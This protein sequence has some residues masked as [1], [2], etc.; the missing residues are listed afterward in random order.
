[1][2][3]GWGTP[4]VY[5][6]GLDLGGVTASSSGT[7]V[8]TGA[9]NTKGNWVQLIASTPNDIS[10]IVL[11]VSTYGVTSNAI[12]VDLACAT[13]G[14]ESS[15]V[16]LSNLVCQTSLPVTHLEIPV[17]VKAGSRIAARAASG[18]ATDTCNIQVIGLNSGYTENVVGSVI[19][20]YGYSGTGAI[21]GVSVDPGGTVNTLGAYAVLTASTTKD[22]MGFWLGFDYLNNVPTA[23]SDGHML[24]NLA[25]GPSTE[26]VVIPN[27]AVCKNMFTGGI[28]MGPSFS[29]FYY[30]PI[31]AGTRVVVNARSA[32]NAAT[33]RLL[34]VSLYGLRA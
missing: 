14:N 15:G 24:L 9:I 27:I 30:I 6:P 28:Q 18:N 31:K 22:L 13:T 11:M 20:T 21:A 8:A 19:D 25:I 1:M 33:D 7:A 2:A 4:L 16:I 12:A 17:V 10:R 23:G 29:S 3:G 5:G 34:G 26:Q 32:S